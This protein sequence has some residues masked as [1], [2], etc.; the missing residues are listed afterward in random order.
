MI[1]VSRAEVCAIACAELFRDAG[2]IMV[3]PF[4]ASILLLGYNGSAIN[5]MGTGYELRV[6]AALVQ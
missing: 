6:I 2:E 5:A 1:A 4:L 3:A